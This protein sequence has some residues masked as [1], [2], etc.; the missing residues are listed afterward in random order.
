MLLGSS[1][2]RKLFLFP[3]SKGANHFHHYAPST[4]LIQTRTTAKTGRHRHLAVTTRSSQN[5]LSVSC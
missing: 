3:A 2:L 4:G 1:L 5:F